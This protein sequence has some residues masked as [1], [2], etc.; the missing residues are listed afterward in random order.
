M[1]HLRTINLGSRSLLEKSRG[2]EL[3]YSTRSM[4]SYLARHGEIKAPA[5]LLLIELVSKMNEVKPPSIADS[6]LRVRV[7][8]SLD[9]LSDFLDSAESDRAAQTISWITKAFQMAV[10]HNIFEE[11]ALEQL[12]QA[13]E[14]AKQEGYSHIYPTAK[15]AFTP[16]RKWSATLMLDHGVTE[17]IGRLQIADRSGQMHSE[18]EVFR[19]RPD[20]LMFR[21]WLVRP[22]WLSNTTVEVI[23][24]PWATQCKPFKL[25]ISD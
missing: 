4:C 15:P 22:K 7:A 10:E 12:Q 14:R 13:G 16:N 17:T 2:S 25:D 20:E 11:S 23:P 8:S 9:E 18:H 1:P 24:K 5:S 19:T 3:E 21:M 6:T